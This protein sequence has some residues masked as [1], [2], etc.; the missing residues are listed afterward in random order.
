MRIFCRRLTRSLCC[1]V[2]L[3]A[4]YAC[5]GGAG[6]PAVVPPHAVLTG[7]VLWN[8]LGGDSILGVLP[9]DTSSGASA[10]SRDGR[11]VIGNST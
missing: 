2:L 8:A 1:A 6:A 11:V 7:A 4:C 10:V 9:G 3:A 5:G